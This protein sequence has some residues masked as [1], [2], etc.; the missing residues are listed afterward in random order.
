MWPVLNNISSKKLHNTLKNCCWKSWPA[1]LVSN[2]A[3]KH[4]R[5]L[6]LPPFTPVMVVAD[7]SITGPGDTELFPCIPGDLYY[8]RKIK[9]Y[10]PSVYF[11]DSHGKTL[12][13]TN[14]QHLSVLLFTELP[15]H[16]TCHRKYDYKH[17]Y[18]SDY[19]IFNRYTFLRSITETNRLSRI[20]AT[21]TNQPRH[22]VST[23]IHQH[24]RVFVYRY[25]TYYHFLD[26]I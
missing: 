21:R 12:S 18:N 5:F 1:S 19:V 23:E 8:Y 16:Y 24:F 26:K 25:Y 9:Y 22:I 10:H 15:L 14:V 20:S 3:G 7:Y 11:Y 4:K 13:I 6:P 2:H 17:S